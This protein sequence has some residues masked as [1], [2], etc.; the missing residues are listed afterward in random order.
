MPLFNHNEIN[1]A[2]DL[3][4]TGCD[5]VKTVDFYRF[6]DEGTYTQVDFLR[7]DLRE[8]FTAAFDLT[9]QQSEDLTFMQTY[10]LSDIVQSTLFE[11]LG[12]G[13]D[14]TPEQLK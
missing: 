4:L 14:Y 6:N 10:K 12:P 5:Y 1:E 9:E 2:D 3:D 7:D 8:P 13:Y 11:G